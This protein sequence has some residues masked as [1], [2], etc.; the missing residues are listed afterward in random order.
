[1]SAAQPARWPTHV[2]KLLKL[3]YECTDVA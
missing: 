2:F 3:L 1:M